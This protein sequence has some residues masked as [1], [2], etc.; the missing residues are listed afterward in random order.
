ME[1]SLSCYFEAIICL[2]FYDRKNDL[3]N[4]IG[5]ILSIH[6]FPIFRLLKTF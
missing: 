2:L 6:F 1:I 3:L 4:P 5:K